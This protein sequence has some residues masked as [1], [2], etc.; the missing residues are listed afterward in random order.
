M[1]Q[2]L[3]MIFFSWISSIFV[4]FFKS[5]RFFVS[6]CINKMLLGNH[7]FQSLDFKFSPALNVV[8]FLLGNSPA[9]EFYIPSFRNTLSL[10]SSQADR[11]E[12]W[13]GLRTWE[14]LYGKFFGSSQTFSLTNTPTF[15]NVVIL[16]TYPP[17]K[18]DHAECSETSAH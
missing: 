2:F 15:S 7:P 17:I 4:G 13:L 8:F 1:V 3:S 11:Y 9:S 10:P 16:H 12:E 14:Y 6:F 18:M 5:S